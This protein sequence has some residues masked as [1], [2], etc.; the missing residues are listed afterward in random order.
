MATTTTQVLGTV[1]A[2]IGEA[3]ATAPDG[4]VRIL[5]VGDKVFTDEV[6]TTSTDGSVKI[7]LEGGGGKSLECG[8]D[9]TIALHESILGTMVAEAPAKPAPA[10]A[11]DVAALQAA[12]AAGADPTQVAEATAAGGAPGAGGAEGG[13]SHEPVVLEQGNSS[14]VVSAGFTTQGGSIEFPAV[15]FEQLPQIATRPIASVSVQ[16]QVD[17]EDQD[18]GGVIVSGNAASLIEGTNGTEGGKLVNFIITLDHPFDQDVQV[19]Y[20]VQPGTASAP[21]DYFDGPLSATVTIPAGETQI[22]VPVFIVEDHLVEGDETFQVVLTDAVNATIDPSANTAV[23]TIVDDDALPVANA[24]TN[25]VQEDTAPVAQGNVL[26]S[27]THSGAPGGTFSDSEDTDHEP[28][29]VTTTG[30]FSGT[31]GTLELNADGSYTYTLDNAHPDV[32][33]LDDGGVLTDTFQYSVTDGFNAPSSSTLT[34]TIFGSNDDPTIT[35]T[36]GAAGTV[37]EAGL[38]VGSGVGPT[39]IVHEG[40]F[41]VADADGLDDVTH[42]RINGSDFA[43]GS[44]VGQTVSGLGGELEIT[45]YDAATGVVSFRYTLQQ[46]TADVADQP[47]QAVF[48]VRVSDDGGVTFSAPVSVTITIVDDVPGA[49]D[50]SDS[51]DEDAVSVSGNV[52]DNDTQGADQTATVGAGTFSGTYGTLELN[53]DGSYTYTLNTASVQHLDAGESVQ[54]VFPYALTDADGDSS[55]ARLTVTIT[56]SNDDPTITVTAGAAGT[57][58]EAGL[59]VGSGVGPTTIVHEG[60][61]QVADA[62]G[63]DDVTH[64]RINGS[65]FAIGS[66]VGQTVSGLGGE[67]EITGYDAATGVVSFRYTLQQATADVADQPEQAVFEVRVSD[68][69]GVTFSAPV[70]VTITIIDDTPAVVAPDGVI[71]NDAGESLVG[72]LDYDMNAD[73]LGRVNLNSPTVTSVGLAHTLS[74]NGEVVSYLVDDVD[75]DGLQELYGYIDSDGDRIRDSGERAVFTLAPTTAAANDGD[76]TLTLHDVVDLP[77]PVT[78]LTFSGISASGP[79]DEISVGGKLLISSV[80]PADDDLNAS[81]GFIGINN[82]VMNGPQG[83]S[84]GETIRYEFG[85]V[86][87]TGNPAD[88]FNIVHEVV[89]DVTLNVFDVGNGVDSFSWIAFKNNIQVGNGNMIWNPDANPPTLPTAIHVDGGYD[90]LQIQVTAGDFKVGGVSFVELGDPQDINLNIAFS[91]EDGDGDPIGGSFNVTIT[92]GNGIAE[93]HII[94]SLLNQSQSL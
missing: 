80:F 53:A 16:V 22:V 42:V 2:V 1:T 57:V 74:S 78:V 18:G 46:A 5:Q 12:I 37:Y 52:R 47:E 72:L 86:T 88:P 13:G 28:L 94:D 39:T 87:A 11:T 79:V 38:A 64:V 27:A 34:I 23:V 29:T 45:G 93:N 26:Q 61:F 77:V 82:N 19:T 76:Y 7:A 83:R 10:P 48:E 65:D 25:W 17:V 58:Y 68:D 67:L 62:D 24:D 50:D 44:L 41:Q 30:T 33:A 49:V 40:T 21:D 15:E 71:E 91:G 20:V 54:E 55:E 9:A 43:I 36:A 60:T 3:K 51:L 70:S 69:G 14:Q 73:G 75:G 92:S 6:I 81:D 35:V 8:N 85:T 32:Q 63:L 31:Y 66:L 89:N 56:G 59:A 4:T 90:T 84:S